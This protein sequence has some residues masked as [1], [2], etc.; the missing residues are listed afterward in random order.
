[1]SLSRKS[2][3]RN[4][5]NYARRLAELFTTELLVRLPRPSGRPARFHAEIIVSLTS[6][7]PRYR[8]LHKT[9]RTLLSQSARPDRVILW[10]ANED[11]PLLP[12]KV[13]RLEA[14]GL[15]IR[16]C[17]DFRSFK[18]LVPSLKAFPDSWIVTA[19]DDL[20]YDRHWLH[21]LVA[22]AEV[23]APFPVIVCHRAMRMPRDPAQLVQSA[24]WSEPTSD[25]RTLVPSDDLYPTTGAGVLYPPHSLH[26]DATKQELF[27]ELSP[28]CDDTWFTW[29]GY[30]AGSRVKRS[31]VHQRRLR[32]WFKTTT[33]SLWLH[34]YAEEGGRRKVDTYLRNMI[35][36]YGA[37]AHDQMKSFPRFKRSRDLL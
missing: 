12:E 27:D 36:R 31:T 37:P 2:A 18:K 9:L 16:A 29:M 23:G 30:M 33:G 3:F 35:T 13:R 34:N 26:G 32:A 11:M 17:A 19:D 6:F 15:E 5:W 4:A 24:S 20:Y 8:T 1:M 10:L 25:E 21:D 22:A 7:P 28:T 14:K